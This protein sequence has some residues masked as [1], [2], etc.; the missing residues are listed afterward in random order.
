ME[1]DTKQCKA[2]MVS[3]P[4]VLQQSLRA[5]LAT[6]PWLILVGTAGDGLSALTL[7]QQQPADILL[8]DSNLLEEERVALVQQIKRCQPTIRCL[9]LVDLERQQQTMLA[10]GVDAVLLRQAS[11]QSLQQVLEQMRQ[12]SEPV[13]KITSIQTVLLVDDDASTLTLLTTIFRKIRSDF[14]ILTA[15]NGRQAWEQHQVHLPDLLWTD[16]RMPNMDGLSLISQVRTV[17][18]DI[19]VVLMTGYGSQVA[20]DLSLLLNIHYLDKP[21]TPA[22]V[23]DLIKTLILD[24]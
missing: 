17:S 15:H 4:G 11:N 5:A 9:A 13:E 18:P 21:F 20:A 2:I 22:Q 1:Q 7:I 23:Q 8:L 6:V 10:A 24:T 19:P 3:R 16:Y 14:N 12:S